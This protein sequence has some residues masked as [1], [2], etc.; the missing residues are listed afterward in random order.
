MANSV[1][2]DQTALRPD[3]SSKS[4]LVRVYTVCQEL[5]VKKKT[6]VSHLHASSLASQ[7]PELNIK[8]K[9]LMELMS[10]ATKSR[11]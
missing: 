8:F 3:C 9:K 7:V 11:G 2:P 5:S 1:N 10:L 4:S 6:S